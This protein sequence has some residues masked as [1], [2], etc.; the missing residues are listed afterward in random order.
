MIARLALLLPCPCSVSLEPVSRSVCQG[1]TQ[2]SRHTAF[3]A[4]AIDCLPNTTP[5]LG[6]ATSCPN[7]CVGCRPQTVRMSAPAQHG[8]SSHH[9]SSSSYSSSQ[10][11]SK[12]APVLVSLPSRSS[13]SSQ[14]S[15]GAAH[16]GQWEGLEGGGPMGG[17][18][19]AGSEH[20]QAVSS[21][22]NSSV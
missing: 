5:Q 8:C 6:S 14:R 1:A 12:A 9:S 17:L 19:A 4:P 13:S 15:S 10:R 20:C 18:I 21:P 22:G 7:S 11:W 3:Q 16:T 2:G